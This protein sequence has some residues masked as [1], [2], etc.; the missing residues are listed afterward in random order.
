MNGTSTSIKSQKELAQL[1]TSEISEGY[2]NNNNSKKQQQQ[3]LQRQHQLVY[4]YVHY[5]E[6]VMDRND[7]VIFDGNIS[8]KIDLILN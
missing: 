7:P 8:F 2:N 4:E 3:Q 6:R 5:T 1:I